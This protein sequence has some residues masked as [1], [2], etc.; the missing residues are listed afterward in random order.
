M[1]QLLILRG[2]CDLSA[3][4][5]FGAVLMAIFVLPKFDGLLLARAQE[6]NSAAKR[7]FRNAA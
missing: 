3:G 5:C 4:A 6:S 2:L 1:T 7:R